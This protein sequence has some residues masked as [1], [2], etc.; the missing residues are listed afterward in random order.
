M[1]WL[2]SPLAWLGAAIAV[3]AVLCAMRA[4]PSLADC[5][6]LCEVR[7]E[8]SV[9]LELLL[10][11]PR[12]VLLWPPL[13]LDAIVQLPVHHCVVADGLHLVL[14][15]VHVA[16]L[17]PS[18]VAVRVHAAGRHLAHAHE[19]LAR[20]HHHRPAVSLRRFPLAPPW[21]T[22]RQRCRQRAAF[23][24][25]LRPL[26]R[27]KDAKRVARRGSLRRTISTDLGCTRLRTQIR[28]R[29]SRAR[30]RGVVCQIDDHHVC[31]R[32]PRRRACAFVAATL[33]LHTSLQ[34]PFFQR[35]IGSLFLHARRPIDV[36][37]A[38]PGWPHFARSPLLPR[39]LH[40]TARS[41]ERLS[42]SS[43]VVA[44][45][46]LDLTFPLD[47]HRHQL[48]LILRIVVFPARLLPWRRSCTRLHELPRLSSC[49]CFHILRLCPRCLPRLLH[50]IKRPALLPHLPLLPHLSPQPAHLTHPDHHDHRFLLVACTSRLRPLLGGGVEIASRRV[51]RRHASRPLIAVA[52]AKLGLM[53]QRLDVT[54]TTFKTCT[55]RSPVW[56]GLIP[57][58]TNARIL[59]PQIFSRTPSGMRRWLRG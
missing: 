37:V 44:A 29:A 28:K 25:A 1:L 6:V 51:L 52:H 50:S 35:F 39:V 55:H 36:L 42:H 48:R 49:S 33:R 57:A 40:L 12:A 9:A 58:V 16:D 20:R 13:P 2:F 56:K 18:A 23:R 4:R 59:P 41:L 22:H 15:L 21:L 38:W 24:R 14:L 53:R 32:R 26:T 17:A 46:P 10:W 27:L 43:L 8:S 7:L 3:A 54:N 34:T 47:R 31:R 11:L 45:F 30:L 19:V 5:A